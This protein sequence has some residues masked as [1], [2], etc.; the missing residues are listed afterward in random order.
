MSTSD[1]PSPF[2]PTSKEPKDEEHTLRRL[3][4][5]LPG[6]PLGPAHT[7]QTTGVP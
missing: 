3:A 2:I 5:L 1:N 7:Q 6:I 4:S